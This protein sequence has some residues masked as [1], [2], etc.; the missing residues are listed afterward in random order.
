MHRYPWLQTYSKECSSGLP[1]CATCSAQTWA[2]ALMFRIMGDWVLICAPVALTLLMASFTAS[3]DSSTG[4][5]KCAMMARFFPLCTIFSK[6]RSV[7]SASSSV[8]KFIGPVAQCFGAYADGLQ[9]RNISIQ[10]CINITKQ[11]FYSS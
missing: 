8:K 4:W 11:I 2:S 7:S 5:L 9:V 3:V 6:V 1:V 10:Y